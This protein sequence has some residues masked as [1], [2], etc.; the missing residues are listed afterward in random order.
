MTLD[1]IVIENYGVYGGRQ[2]ANLSPEPDRP[3]I[4]FGGM[5]GGGKTTLLDAIQLAF[6]GKKARLSNRGRLPY[7][8]YLHDCIHRAAD[9]GEGAGITLRYRRFT[10]GEAHDYEL[11]RHWRQGIKG[12]E[13]NFRVL[14]DGEPDPLLI[15]HWDES[16]AS[17]LPVRLAHLFFFDGEQIKDLAEGDHV[18]EIIGS[19]IEGLLGLDLV[20]RLSTD[21]KV[22]ERGIR[23][24]QRKSGEED[25][26]ARMIRQGEG[27]MAEIDRSLEEIGNA[28]G[29]K[30]NEANQ[31]AKI[32]KER[33]EQFESVGGHLY[34]RQADLEQ[35][36]TDL[37]R[38]RAQ[39]ETELRDLVAG[40]LPLAVVDELLGEVAD[41]ARHETQIRH[42]RVLLEALEERD[43][44]VMNALVG[45]DDAL[46]AATAGRID[47]F[48]AEDRRQRA[49]LAHEPMILHAD[50]QLP[51]RISHLR[52]AL[53]PDAR[54]QAKAITDRLAAI[55]EQLSRLAGDL[56]R[57]PPREHIADCQR[58]LERARTSH[59]SKL[60]EIN[61]LRERRETL[62]RQ[63]SMVNERIGRLGLTDLD[64]RYA[65]DDR[66]R[67]L[68]HAALVR[69][70]LDRLRPR[71]VARHAERIESLMYD[72]FLQLLHKPDLVRGLK[73]DPNTYAATLT[74]SDG[75]TLPFDRLS[76]GER[77]L[78]ATAM[79]WGLA[80]ASGRPIPTIIDTPLG[81]LDSS[82]RRNLVERYFPHASH[83]V[84][85]LSTDEEIVGLY[86]EAIAPYVAR[87]YMLATLTHGQTQIFPG[88][89]HSDART[90]D[91]RRA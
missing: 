31:L 55:D 70:T 79:L 21:L 16:I 40:P 17:F 6:Y 58:A 81:R 26:T 90:R 69:D 47:R 60:A 4:R 35:R 64:A 19:A 86:W 56:A 27:E 46:A 30:V 80:R 2:E 82:H 13:E 75:R 67:M 48:L 8:D 84:I 22:F 62:K 74:G 63:Q 53:I 32:L 77:Q 88:Y 54:N 24:D 44:Q 83:Q 72:S 45:T 23:D 91:H 29:A 59:E 43:R 33:E 28:E 78:L 71:V 65:D 61:A 18:A 25:E 7:L 51:A 20:E 37:T 89:F 39:A 73:V 34:L 9:P 15:E 42:A 11:Q 76:A 14:R 5:N 1:Q 87:T 85:L 49:G 50:D 38:Q 52:T 41:Q 36:K 12:V 66:S 68:K 57:V 10:D 3:I